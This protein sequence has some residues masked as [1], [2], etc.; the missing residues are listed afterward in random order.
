[1]YLR[2]KTVSQPTP[3]GTID[4]G[5]KIQVAKHKQRALKE[6]TIIYR[7]QYNHKVL[8]STSYDTHPDNIAYVCRV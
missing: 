1:M 4:F 8:L 3:M 5:T 6:N 7:V 2:G